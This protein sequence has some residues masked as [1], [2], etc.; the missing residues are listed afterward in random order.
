[1]NSKNKHPMT[2]LEREHVER[3]KS[4][5]CSVCGVSGPCQAHEIVQGLWFL[6]ISLCMDCHTN[7]VLGWHGQKRAW[8]IRKMDELK[9][10]NIT[11]AAVDR[12]H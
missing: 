10:L 6:S 5:N 11:L 7:P 9:A 3:V 2:R 4:Q 8:I 1:M 12:E